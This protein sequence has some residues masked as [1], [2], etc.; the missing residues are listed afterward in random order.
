MQINLVIINKIRI[1]G[2][3]FAIGPE[4]FWSTCNTYMYVCMHKCSLVVSNQANTH[5]HHLIDLLLFLF[6]QPQSEESHRIFPLLRKNEWRMNAV[7][8]RLVMKIMHYFISKRVRDVREGS[9][10]NTKCSASH[11]SMSFFHLLPYDQP[12]PPIS[13]QLTVIL[14][15]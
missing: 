4:Q 14:H 10:R 11:P 3:I 1:I 5:P 7:Y 9:I 12:T 2:A 8:S 15:L 6:C 13:K